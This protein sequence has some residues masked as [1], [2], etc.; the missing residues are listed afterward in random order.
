METSASLDSNNDF[1]DRKK[2]TVEKRTVFRW[3]P[4]LFENDLVHGSYWLFLGSVVGIVIPIMP[5]IALYENWWPPATDSSGNELLPGTP[6]TTAVR[7]NLF[8]YN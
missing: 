1:V 7:Y 3:L 4:V 5:L 6:H 2:N 8:M